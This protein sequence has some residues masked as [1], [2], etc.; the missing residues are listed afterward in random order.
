MRPKGVFWGFVCGLE[1]STKLQELADFCVLL[2][3]LTSWVEGQK[4]KERTFLA[5]KDFLINVF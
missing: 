3:L 1:F 5:K 2:S 4:R